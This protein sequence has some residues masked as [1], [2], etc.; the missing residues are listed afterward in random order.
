MFLS[1]N[2]YK[3][4]KVFLEEVS[5][6]ERERRVDRMSFPEY[7]TNAVQTGGV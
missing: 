3:T 1:R 2:N 5:E 6:R 7:L 4:E